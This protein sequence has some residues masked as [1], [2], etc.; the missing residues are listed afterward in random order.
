MEPQQETDYVGA[1]LEMT[2]SPGG[3]YTVGSSLKQLCVLFCMRFAR[4][5]YTSPACMLCTECMLGA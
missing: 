3:G 4:F 2:G 5:M 1:F